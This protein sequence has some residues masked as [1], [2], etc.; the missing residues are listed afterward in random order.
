MSADV[1]VFERSKAKGFYQNDQ[2]CKCVARFSGWSS[3]DFISDMVNRS[4]LAEGTVVLNQ[5]NELGKVLK[6]EEEYYEFLAEDMKHHNQ[7]FYYLVN[8]DFFEKALDKAYFESWVKRG[9]FTEGKTDLK[10]QLT[11]LKKSV[12]DFNFDENYYYVTYWI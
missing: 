2:S 10:K 1:Y 6:N 4:F 9:N 8:K 11:E 7:E 12:N 3:Y 5:E